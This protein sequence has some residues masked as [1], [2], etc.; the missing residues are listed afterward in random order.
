MTNGNDNRAVATEF[1]SRMNANDLDAA[2]VLLDDNLEWTVPSISRFVRQNKEELYRN[3]SAV[4]EACNGT[5]RIVPLSMISE[6]DRIA[7]EAES[8]ADLPNGK[9]FHNKYHFMWVIK[10]GRI[11]VAH[12]YYDTAHVIQVMDPA[13][14]HIFMPNIV[15]G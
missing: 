15:R 14:A 8:F 4:F 11:C 5:Y 10:D 12:E 6:G 9:K 13:R 3:V 7:V 1:L 2:F